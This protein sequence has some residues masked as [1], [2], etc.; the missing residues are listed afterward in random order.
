VNSVQRHTAYVE[1]LTTL[2]KDS[3]EET[4]RIVFNRFRILLDKA[5][6]N[7]MAFQKLV[8]ADRKNMI[9]LLIKAALKKQMEAQRL[10]TEFG[11]DRASKQ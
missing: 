9:G 7:P 2:T 1:A 10:G 4:K 11:R 6:G 8:A 5:G 3:K